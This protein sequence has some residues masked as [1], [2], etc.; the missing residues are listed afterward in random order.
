MQHDSR[1]VQPLAKQDTS[2]KIDE[3]LKSWFIKQ[4][5]LSDENERVPVFLHAGGIP[6]FSSV[7]VPMVDEKRLIV[8]LENV[9]PSRKQNEIV[10]VIM[11]V[12]Y[13]KSYQPGQ[14]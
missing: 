14:K 7:I 3:L 8:L 11:S 6:G 13:N 2:A 1:F 10:R 4:L 12:L 5:L 9:M